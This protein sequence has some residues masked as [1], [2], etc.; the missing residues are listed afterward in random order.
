M[1]LHAHAPSPSPPYRSLRPSLSG[2]GVSIG[3]PLCCLGQCRMSPIGA[4]S[5]AALAER[6]AVGIANILPTASERRRLPARIPSL[7]ARVSLQM[8][9]LQQHSTMRS[10]MGT[11]A[12]RSSIVTQA[13]IASDHDPPNGSSLL[14]ARGSHDHHGQSSRPKNMPGNYASDT[15]GLFLQ[16]ATPYSRH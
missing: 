6:F 9:G 10:K 13:S 8:R 11:R 15:G 16:H 12:S 3:A 2:G 7:V 4:A 1:D 5:P 14:R